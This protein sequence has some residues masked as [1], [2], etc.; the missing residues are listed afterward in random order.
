MTSTLN[1]TLSFHFQYN[2]PYST[3]FQS[4]QL[5]HR[6]PNN[7]Y[8]FKALFKPNFKEKSEYYFYLITK[9]IQFRKKSLIDTMVNLTLISPPFNPLV[10]KPIQSLHTL[11]HRQN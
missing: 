7:L 9:L 5:N 3:D 8:Q 4:H 11:I 6:A 10:L 2:H 1:P